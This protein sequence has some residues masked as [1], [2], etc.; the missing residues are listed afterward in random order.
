MDW[1]LRKGKDEREE[2]GGTGKEGPNAE[3]AREVGRGSG[4]LF[5]LLLFGDPTMGFCLMFFK[6]FL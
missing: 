5:V 4:R 6:T 3:T 1:L 2:T